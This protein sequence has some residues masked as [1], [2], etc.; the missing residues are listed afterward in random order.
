MRF[1]KLIRNLEKLKLNKSAPFFGKLKPSREQS[2]AEF[3]EPEKPS[4]EMQEVSREEFIPSGAPPE[5]LESAA[6]QMSSEEAILPETA[7]GET[8]SDKKESIIIKYKID[9]TPE[10]AV[11]KEERS[12]LIDEYLEETPALQKDEIFQSELQERAEAADIE[13]D[14]KK[15]PIDESQKELEEKNANSEEVSNL[16]EEEKKIQEE[17]IRETEKVKKDLLDKI[18]ADL[19]KAEQEEQPEEEEKSSPP[20]PEKKPEAPKVV[21]EEKSRWKERLR[22]IRMKINKNAA[23][24]LRIA[25]IPFRKI[26]AQTR[27]TLGVAAIVIIFSIIMVAIFIY[28][29]GAH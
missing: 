26:D 11:K 15:P 23:E 6:A 19:P 3:S 25:N 18:L 12:F 21:I 5:S 24:P 20:E 16:T 7:A 28:I 29:R 14:N 2:S 9:E 13:I 17:V 8:I 27:M 22:I 10:E 1:S 4:A